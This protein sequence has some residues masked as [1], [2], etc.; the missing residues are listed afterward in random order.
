[1]AA[2]IAI[3]SVGID[4]SSLAVIA[5]AL[6]VGIGFGLRNLVGNFI[7]GISLLIERPIKVGDWIAVDGYEGI[8]K[9]VAVRA[10]EIQTFQ[11]AAVMIPNLRLIENP[12]TN[13]THKGRT[14]RIDVPIGVA[15]GTDTQKVRDILMGIAE[16]DERIKETPAP[17]VIFAAHG[18]SSLD[19]VLRAHTANVNERLS[20]ASDLRF[21]IDKAFR[22]AKIEIPFPQRDVH[23]RDLDDPKPIAK[24]ARAGKTTVRSST[25]KPPSKPPG[26][27]PGGRG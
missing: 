23:I 7:S 17:N 2:I 5:G 11:G 19:F 10:T 16:A 22:K 4:L 12:V 24:A 9:K 25:R 26:R 3:D 1:L 20:I 6:S 8:V 14:G 18:D 13:L 15:Y 21:E 27:K